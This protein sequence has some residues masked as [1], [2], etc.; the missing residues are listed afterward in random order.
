M[1]FDFLLFKKMDQFCVKNE[2]KY[3]RTFKI[4]TVAFG[5][6]SMSRTQAELWY[7]RFKEGR[8]DVNNDARST[9]TSKN[10]ET[11]EAM[12]KMILDNRRITVK[13]DD[14]VGISF[15]NEATNE[16]YFKIAKC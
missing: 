2:I 15:D 11:I 3:A 5:E 9:R 13:Q 8:E 6:P 1:L 14:D 7:N 10:D 16:D 12:Q 4:L